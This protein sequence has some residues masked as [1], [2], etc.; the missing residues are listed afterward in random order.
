MLASTSRYIEPYGARLGF[1][2]IAGDDGKVRGTVLWRPPMGAEEG[3][4]LLALDG[5]DDVDGC[6]YEGSL[7]GAVKCRS[8]ELDLRDLPYKS[9][10]L[11]LLCNAAAR[12]ELIDVPPGMLLGGSCC[13]AVLPNTGLSAELAR[14]AGL[15]AGALSREL[16][17]KKA[18]RSA[19]DKGL[20]PT[21]PF[22]WLSE[23]GACTAPTAIPGSH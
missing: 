21:P 3:R 19:G 23:E 20:F 12:S 11:Q 13:E 14:A 6:V 4:F 2:P 15:R 22:V 1:D 17:R 5:L 16:S 10:S 18:S 7:L 9:L 8:L